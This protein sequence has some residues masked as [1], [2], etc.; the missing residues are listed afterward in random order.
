MNIL[1]EGYRNSLYYVTYNGPP[2]TEYA[3]YKYAVCSGDERSIIRAIEAG[4]NIFNYI[5]NPSD[6]VLAAAIIHDNLFLSSHHK[7]KGNKI[8]D[9]AIVKKNTSKFKEYPD[10]Y[11]TESELED[12]LSYNS[13]VYKDI[14]NKTKRMM[15]I[16]LDNN[17]KI[18]FD[19]E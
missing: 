6:N 8:L 15:L 7:Y 16:A 2:N 4:C 10:D 1:K 13:S 11:F 3:V 17:P 18:I 5:E 9:I 14:K 12:I 19:M